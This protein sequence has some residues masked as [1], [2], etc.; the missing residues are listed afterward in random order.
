M[1]RS[2]PPVGD[3]GVPAV[4]AVGVVTTWAAESIEALE[5][6]SGVIHD[7]YF[8]ADDVRYDGAARVL[9]VPFA[10]EWPA[11]N[12]REGRSGGQQPKSVP[13]SWRRKEKRVPF[14]RGLVSV[15]HVDSF[16]PDESAGDAGILLGISYDADARRLTIE[17]VSGVLAALVERIDVTVELREDEVALYVVRRRGLLG[18]SEKPLW[19]ENER[20][21]DV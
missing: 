17:G 4:L 13:R 20:A 2:R 5:E 16:A 14:M 11:I 15:A 19:T 10:Q 1:G 9:R 6:L 18:G 7:A 12:E 21:A 3:T 8:D